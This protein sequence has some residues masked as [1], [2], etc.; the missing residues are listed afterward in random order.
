MKALVLTPTHPPVEGRDVHAVYKRLRMFV[1]ALSR[2]SD[3]IEILHFASPDAPEWSMDPK[4]LDDLQ[5]RFWGVSVSVKLAPRRNLPMRWWEYLQSL[6]SVLYRPRY[7]PYGG[8]EQAAAISMCLKDSPQIV[9]VHKLMTMVRLPRTEV[10]VTV[11]FDLDDVEHRVKI[12]AALSASSL[13]SK[14]S[15]FLQAPAIYFAEKRAA[16]RA[17]RTFVCSELDRQYLERLGFPHVRAINNALPL[18]EIVPVVVREQ[19]ILFL[20]TYEYRPNAVAAGRLVSR[21]WP[22]I[23]AQCPQARLIIAG[24]RPDLIP[25]YNNDLRNL[26]FPG[27]VPDLS[28]LY[29]RSRI[30]CCPITMGGGTRIKLVEAA[31]YAKPMIST[32]VGAEGLN[33]IDGVEILI[34]DSDAQIADACVK[35]LT[36]DELCVQLGNSARRKAELQFDA[37]RVQ[38]TIEQ[39]LREIVARWSS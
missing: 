1:Q 25:G 37:G 11:V 35:L 3:S 24:K 12:R 33:F 5:S 38:Q 6:F 32:A 8:R 17:G 36:N 21:I 14:L 15:H 13:V 4:L 30:I 26:E 16:R 9:F 2:I 10:G 23:L 22:R 28:A 31:G 7:Y 29:K 19:T 34:C 20:G 39:N 18:P 27:I